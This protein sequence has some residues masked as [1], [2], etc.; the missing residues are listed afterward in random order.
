M[1][2][3]QLKEWILKLAK[4]YRKGALT[5]SERMANEYLKGYNRALVDVIDMMDEMK[6]QDRNSK[7]KDHADPNGPEGKDTR[8]HQGGKPPA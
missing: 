3:R 2:L 6:K 7:P 5:L 1:N 8:D 4:P